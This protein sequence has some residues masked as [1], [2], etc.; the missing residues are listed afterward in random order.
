MCQ[1]YY[2]ECLQAMY[3]MLITTLTRYPARDAWMGQVAT[4]V[5]M[6]HENLSEEQQKMWHALATREA[7]TEDTGRV[8]IGHIKRW[9]TDLEMLSDVLHEYQVIRNVELQT[10]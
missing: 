8:A 9:H 3:M 6:H 5:G 2:L 4:E 7:E 10:A 1:A